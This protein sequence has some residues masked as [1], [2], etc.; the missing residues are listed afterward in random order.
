MKA[1]LVL[2]LILAACAGQY[3]KAGYRLPEGDLA[4]LTGTF[5][6]H[7]QAELEREAALRGM[8]VAAIKRGGGRLLGFWDARMLPACVIHMS[9]PEAFTHEAWHCKRGSW[10]R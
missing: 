8:D 9:D 1:V 6:L 7:T 5:H 4:P 3:D 2:P 10:H